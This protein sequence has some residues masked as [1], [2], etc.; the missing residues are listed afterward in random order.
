M[1][2]VSL[3]SPFVVITT[4]EFYVLDVFFSPSIE[5]DMQASNSLLRSWIRDE[6]ATFVHWYLSTY[7]G[8]RIRCQPKRR[9]VQFGAAKDFRQR[10]SYLIDSHQSNV[11]MEAYVMTCK[12]LGDD[13]EFQSPMCSSKVWLARRIINLLRDPPLPEVSNGE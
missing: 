7:V 8:R 12:S 9:Q 10:S 1:C 4:N 5:I 13:S 6:W 3:P 2:V 11:Y